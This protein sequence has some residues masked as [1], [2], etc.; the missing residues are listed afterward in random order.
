MS[1]CK[2]DIPIFMDKT[3]IMN[4]SVGFTHAYRTG[5][6]IEQRISYSNT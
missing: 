2:G 1:P 4:A 3:S 6:N 5:I